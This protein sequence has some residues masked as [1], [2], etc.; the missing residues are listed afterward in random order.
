MTPA[1]NNSEVVFPA[2]SIGTMNA[3]G[4]SLDVGRVDTSVGDVVTL[5]W[6]GR[7]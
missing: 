6:G 5:A 4:E 7:A 1:Y 3:N 2:A